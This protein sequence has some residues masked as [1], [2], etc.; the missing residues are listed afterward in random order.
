MAKII[1]FPVVSPAKLGPRKVR[2]SK[3]KDPEDFGQLNLFSQIIPDQRVRSINNGESFFEA[4]L[5]L[6]E[7]GDKS[8]E[9]LYLKAIEAGQSL[10]DAYCNLGIIMSGKEEYA[11]AVDFLTKCLKEDPRHFEAHYNLGNVYSDMG[12]YALAKMH[13]EVSTEIEPDF[14]NSFYNLGLVLISLRAYK[15]ASV[16]INKY[17]QL[18]PGYDHAVA[19]DLVNTLDNFK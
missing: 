11:K 2:K 6:D 14:P 8:A 1:Q 19:S 5:I 4:A 17:I 3:R 16:A 12:N 9:S 7:K 13:Y 18:S 10:P 15:E